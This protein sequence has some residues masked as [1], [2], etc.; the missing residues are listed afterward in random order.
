M[1]IYIYIFV[2][3]ECGPGF[4]ANLEIMFKDI[5]LSSDV[6]QA[7]HV[8]HS[9]K[10]EGF[11]IS[12]NVLSMGNWPTY[13]V[14]NVLMPENLTK[15]RDRF[16]PHLPFVSHPRYNLQCCVS[17]PMHLLGRSEACP[18]RY[19]LDLPREHLTVPNI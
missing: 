13:P 9:K 19:Q 18:H 15:A 4:T 3:V 7:Y 5:E 12:V 6:M 17:L 2:L 8:Q 10:A 16:A 11:E 1:L 14:N